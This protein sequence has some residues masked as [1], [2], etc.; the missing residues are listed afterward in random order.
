M[1]LHFRRPIGHLDISWLPF[2]PVTSVE[3]YSEIP[4]REFSRDRL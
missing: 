2:V 1:Q 4:E 3:T